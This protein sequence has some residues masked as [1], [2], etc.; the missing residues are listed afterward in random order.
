MS[1]ISE[2]VERIKA[3][4]PRYNRS[5]DAAVRNP[6]TGVTL[7]ARARELA[8]GSAKKKTSE[9]Y[10]T[11]SVRVE[12]TYRG[13]LSLEKRVKACGYGSITEWIK[14]C[15]KQLNQ[16]YAEKNTARQTETA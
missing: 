16:E 6:D 5:Y 11:I 12:R 3:E 1:D 8:N 7:K 14:Y 10:K 2:R 13:V 9:T 15:I 4:Y